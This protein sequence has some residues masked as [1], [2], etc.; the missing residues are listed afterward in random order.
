MPPFTPALRDE[1]QNLFDTCITRPQRQTTVNSLTA[2]LLQPEVDQSNQT[3]ETVEP[4]SGYHRKADTRRGSRKKDVYRV[5][6]SHRQFPRGRSESLND[7][8]LQ[9]PT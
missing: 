6:R 1:Y 5:Q 4:V 7:I 3:A 9:P 8:L 2:T